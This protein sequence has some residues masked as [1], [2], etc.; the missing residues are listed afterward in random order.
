MKC[1][2]AGIRIINDY[3]F[4]NRIV[5]FGEDKRLVRLFDEYKE[6][7]LFVKNILDSVKVCLIEKTGDA[8]IPKVYLNGMYAGHFAEVERMHQ[9]N[10]L[11]IL[12]K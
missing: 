8:I 7:P 10:D 4:K 11:D 5:V 1:N 9:R 6:K 2:E 3:I 12:F